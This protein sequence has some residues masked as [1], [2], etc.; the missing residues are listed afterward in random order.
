MFDYYHMNFKKHAIKGT[1]KCFYFMSTFHKK[2]TKNIKKKYF[3]FK[4]D[5]F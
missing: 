1:L 5:M 2:S 4:G 3:I